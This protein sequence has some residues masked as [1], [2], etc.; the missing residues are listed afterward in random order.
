MQRLWIRDWMRSWGRCWRRCLRRCWRGGVG[1][2][3]G[4]SRPE[5]RSARRDN[6]ARTAAT[7]GTVSPNAT[8]VHPGERWQ[9]CFCGNCRAKNAGE[10]EAECEAECEAE[11][12]AESGQLLLYFSTFSTLLPPYWY[13]NLLV[14]NIIYMYI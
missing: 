9:S 14:N 2:G 3:A 6:H 12:E 5:K 10:S 1:G 11:S 13:G 8:P 4:H 7:R